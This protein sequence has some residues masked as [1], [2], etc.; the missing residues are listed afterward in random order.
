MILTKNLLELIVKKF[1]LFPIILLVSC[2]GNGLDQTQLQRVVEKKLSTVSTGNLQ[3]QLE[4]FILKDCKEPNENRFVCIVDM[5]VRS[6]F[7]EASIVEV[8]EGCTLKIKRD[9]FGELLI[10]SNNF[11]CD[12]IEKSQPGDENIQALVMKEMQRS[13]KKGTFD[14]QNLKFK[15]FLVKG[16]NGKEPLWNELTCAIDMEIKFID[17]G[18]PKSLK[19][20]GCSFQLYRKT[21]GV[22]SLSEVGD[23][24]KK[25]A[26][27]AETTQ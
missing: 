14:I 4:K 19:F 5:E 2:G 20:E 8:L 26:S 6:N 24:S 11:L 16:C 25:C 1:F 23:F 17:S 10:V 22:W 13:A 12:A 21:I 15:N 27:I 18:E 7:N 9:E 3:A